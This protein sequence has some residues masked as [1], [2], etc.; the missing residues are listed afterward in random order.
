MELCHG[1]HRVTCIVDGDT[2]W[3]HGEKIRI[4]NIDAPEVDAPCAYERHLAHRA[5]LRFRELVSA[6]TPVLVRSGKDRYGRTLADV[7]VDGRDVGAVLVKESL[8]RPWLGH[9]EHWCD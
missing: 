7:A 9:K 1:S 3:W 5:T 8:A 6:G 4:A 2:F